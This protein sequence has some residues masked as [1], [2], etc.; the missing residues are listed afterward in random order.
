MLQLISKRLL[1][2]VL[3]LYTASLVGG[4]TSTPKKE[5]DAETKPI[6]TTDAQ[7]KMAE[8]QA[9]VEVG[10][11]MAGRLLQAFSIYQNEALTNYVNQV[12]NYVASHSP[13]PER[14][15][16]FQLLDS[17]SVNAF[18]CPGG[19]ILVTVGAVRIAENEAEL[20]A[21]LG[22]EVTHVHRMHMFNTLRKMDKAQMEKSADET[23]NAKL[24][25]SVLARARPKAEDSAFGN[26][27]ARYLASAGGA[28]I[29]V[30]MAAAAGMG[31]ILKK[32]LDKDYEYEADLGGVKAAVDAGYDPRA[33]LA[34]LG[35]LQKK[36]ADLQIAVLEETHPKIEDRRLRIAK[37]LKDMNAQDI[38]GALGKERFERVA[39]DIPPA[40]RNKG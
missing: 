5:E 39:G 10:R 18:A 6:V 32:G 2:A 20:A 7:K 1:S 29:N 37:L 27:M 15:Y 19:Y 24:P 28:G 8:M 14:N 11:S 3:L 35:R 21:I 36:K 13:V 34:F 17:D 23:G 38:V 16:M 12:G 33:M 9:E 26:M 30:I 31:V 25:E 4:C 40:K 22:H